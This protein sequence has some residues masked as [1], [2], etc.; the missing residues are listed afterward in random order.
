MKKLMGLLVLSA[1]VAGCGGPATQAE[2]WKHDTMYRD[3]DHMRFSW[4]GHK[5]VSSEELKKSTEEGWWGKP[6]PVVPPK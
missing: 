1:C 5:T 3:W 2:M 6:V 4:G